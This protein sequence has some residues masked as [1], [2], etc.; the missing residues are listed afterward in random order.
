M[1]SALVLLAAPGRTDNSQRNMPVTELT[2]NYLYTEEK[3]QGEYY[4]V[5]IREAFSEEVIQKLDPI[6]EKASKLQEQ[7]EDGS[8]K[9][10]LQSSEVKKETQYERPTKRL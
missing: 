3:E 8:N 2:T 5:R 10:S 9:R 7:G 4:L 6:S 1:I